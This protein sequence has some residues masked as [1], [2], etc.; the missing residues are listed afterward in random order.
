MEQLHPVH[1]GSDK[2][3]ILKSSRR[4][5]LEAAGKR[6][7]TSTSEGLSIHRSF[8]L[9]LHA[10]SELSSGEISGQVE[11]V[12]S[13][14]TREFGSVGDLLKSIGLLLR[15]DNREARKQKGN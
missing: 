8:L 3:G 4:T 6:Q 5:T 1:V 7:G 11:H 2:G 14:E 15:N 12:V 13:G 10:G 9:R